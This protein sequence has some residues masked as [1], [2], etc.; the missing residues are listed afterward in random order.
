M[1]RLRG[2]AAVHQL[3]Q[4]IHVDACKGVIVHYMDRQDCQNRQLKCLSERSLAR[5]QQ[6][7]ARGCHV[8]LSSSC[9]RYKIVAIPIGEAQLHNVIDPGA[10]L[11]LPL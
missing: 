3:V 7:A 5:Q 10:A 1:D 9:E 6:R 2:Y 8:Q 4:Q 11:R